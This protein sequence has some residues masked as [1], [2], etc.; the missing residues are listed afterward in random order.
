[1]KINRKHLVHLSRDYRIGHGSKFRL[2]DAD[3]A[4]CS[5]AKIIRH[6]EELLA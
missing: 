2:K 1:M 6:A 5:N 3:T 4:G